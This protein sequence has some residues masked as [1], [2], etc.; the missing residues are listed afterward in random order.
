MDT[1]GR[2]PFVDQEGLRIRPVRLVETSVEKGQ[3]MEFRLLGPVGV[4]EGDQPVQVG[5]VK[6]L[7]LLTVLLLAPS[8][9]APQET[10]ARHLWPGAGWDRQNIRR[11]AADLRK[12]IGPE[13]LPR[14]VAGSYRLDIAR[15]QVDY[16]RF[17]DAMAQAR[18]QRG[19][20]RVATLRR[21]LT[22]WRGIPLDGLV[23]MDFEL[24]K[25]M[26]VTRWL[27]AWTA[28]LQAE[29]D[30]GDPSAVLD[31]IQIPTMRC[32][33]DERLL[34][35]HL[36]ALAAC[37]RKTEVEEV[38]RNYVDGL[39]GPPGDS[40]MK[41]YEELTTTKRAPTP[42]PSKSTPPGLPQ[43]L[44]A[45]RA[46]LIGREKAMRELNEVLLD[47]TT[48]TT[49][50]AVLSGMAGVG[51]TELALHW[52]A[53]AKGTFADGVLYA[54]L[55]GFA[56]SEP[57]HP[58][59]IL[60]RFLNDL[61]VE[62][63]TATTDGMATAYRSALATRSVLV[64]L[65]NARDADQVR[66]LLPGTRSCATV[67]TS[68]D[69]LDSVIVRE[70]ARPIKIAPL[71][72]ADCAALLT[73]ILGE[74]RVRKEQHYVEELV[75]LCARLPLAVT[76]VAAR[77]H[78]R[79]T[80]LLGSIVAEL[81]AEKTKLN[82]LAH[83]EPDLDMRAVLETS[84]R[85][86]SPEAARLFWQLAVHPGPTIS[87]SAL[88]TLMGQQDHVVRQA[89]DE[90]LVAHL[91]EEASFDRFA[92]HDL[93]RSYAEERA[94][95]VESAEQD[96]AARRAFDY[97]LHAAWACDQVLVPG[98]TLPIGA[99]PQGMEIPVP[100]STAQAMAW[101]DAEYT[102]MLAAIRRA[103]ERG[104]HRYTWL[105][106]MTLVTFQWR[107]GRY[108]DAERCL[109][110]A[111]A[112]AEQAGDERDRAM[113]HR[114]IAGTFRGLGRTELAKAHLNRAIMLCTVGDD[115]G[116]AHGHHALA[117]M[118]RES[119]ESA[120]AVEHYDLA[121]PH[122]QRLGDRQGEA[123][124]LNGLGCT[125]LDQGEHVRALAHCTEALKLFES[126][127]DY[128]GQAS[129]LDSLGRIHLAQGHHE[130]GIADFRSAVVRYRDLEYAKN[131]AASLVRLADALTT[132]G[133]ST[134]VREVLQ[135]AVHLLRELDDPTASEVAARLEAVE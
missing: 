47:N 72:R 86:V 35:I 18:V 122:F 71:S 1:G 57:E 115:L 43:Q 81:R 107:R 42:H 49:R 39:G 80:L 12:Q 6:A 96:L 92:F 10:I 44:P 68:R 5:S 84:H 65:D 108:L 62:A 48:T 121:L 34:G 82:A 119:G 116:L 112:P 114:M 88:T 45:H 76:I 97:L 101:F 103:E 38:F 109:R 11:C 20:E 130:F 135:R 21:S 134:E 28:F 111:V 120:K 105:M 102:T 60:A 74:A 32:P 73:A 31:L 127:E 94:S 33:G 22:E 129:A 41:L 15:E 83:I 90:L 3:A 29:L 7:G 37:S 64:V 4:I 124:V 2:I 95:A 63:R 24:E 61:G 50:I 87:R 117:I 13:V 75:D 125:L 99:P 113:V 79:P 126:T 100:S 110:A 91:L 106:A 133:Q 89:L 131:E 8:L 55:N 104:W 69:R 36:K 46:I 40:L 128:N 30:A 58:E 77:A 16:L 52:S 25:S 123:G 51:K 118:H 59:Q 70:G 56:S 14:S 53:A 27:E 98:R 9:S 67:I 54:N 17:L 19:A 66:Q 93:L 78:A 23:G 26:L 85:T 132:A